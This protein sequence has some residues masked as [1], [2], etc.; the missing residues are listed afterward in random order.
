MVFVFTIHSVTTCTY[1][2]TI[3]NG[4][5]VYEDNDILNKKGGGIKFFCKKGFT[6][7][8]VDKTLCTATGWKDPLP[9]CKGEYNHILLTCT[10]DVH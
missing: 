6:L 10:E 7:D 4:W 9:T 2:N 3:S 8:G 5:V 1:I